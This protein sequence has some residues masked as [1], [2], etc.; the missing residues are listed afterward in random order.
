MNRENRNNF[1]LLKVCTHRQPQPLFQCFYRSNV[2]CESLLLIKNSH[3]LHITIRIL[4]S[5]I[6]VF[7]DMIQ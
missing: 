2:K 4:Q 7:P 3:F 1:Y 5:N 6:I